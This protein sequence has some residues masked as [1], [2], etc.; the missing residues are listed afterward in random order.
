MIN[1]TQEFNF[2]EVNVRFT[3]NDQRGYPVIVSQ[4]DCGI[5]AGNYTLYH[6]ADSRILEDLNPTRK[7]DLL[8]LHIS[9]AINIFDVI[10]R[11]KPV[12]TAFDHVMELGHPVGRYRW[13]YDFTYNKIKSLPPAS[14][15]VL[16]WGERMDI[17]VNTGN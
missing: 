8:V 5:S 3:M 7:V 17:G 15:F 1:S 12:A 6:I 11:V 13:S 2:G 16:T 10:D 14:S 9:N 4:I